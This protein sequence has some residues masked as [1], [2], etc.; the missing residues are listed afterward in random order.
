MI[1]AIGHRIAALV[2]AATTLVWA[3]AASA[4]APPRAGHWQGAVTAHASG[5]SLAL[6]FNGLAR[7]GAAPPAPMLSHASA[8]DQLLDNAAASGLQVDF[9]L[10][11]ALTVDGRISATA[12]IGAFK[13]GPLS[14]SVDLRRS[15]RRPC[16]LRQI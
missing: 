11:R 2:V 14:A 1:V 4:S 9:S 16:P 7:S 15:A 5:L 6:D 13:G 12:I 3:T 10:G 8:I